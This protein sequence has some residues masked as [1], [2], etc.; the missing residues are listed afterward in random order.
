MQERSEKNNDLKNKI[1]EKEKEQE[2][3]K[4]KLTLK[5]QEETKKVKQDNFENLKENEEKSKEILKEYEEFFESGIPEDEEIDTL[6]EKCLLIEKYRIQIKNYEVGTESKNEIQNLKELFQD[7]D[8]TE[9][10]N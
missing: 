5:L 9:E 2:E 6:I 4:K 8:I 3:L 7:S 1:K 10:M